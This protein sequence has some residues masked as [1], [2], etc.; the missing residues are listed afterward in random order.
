MPGLRLL[1]VIPS[2]DPRDGGPVQWV[3]A[4]NRELARRGHTSAVASFDAPGA[5][6]LAGLPF[7]T[8]PLGPG[9]G[10]YGFARGA[11]AQ[12]RALSAQYDALIVDGLWQY[13][14]AA[15]SAALRGRPTPY[16]VFPHGMLD[17]WFKNAYPLKHLKKLPYWAAFERRVLRHAA[18][19]IFTNAVEAGLATTSFPSSVWTAE[20]VRFGIE[21]VP[22]NGDALRRRFL[23]THPEL[24]G[25]R[26]LTFLGRLHEKKGYDLL[27]QAFARIADTD[28]AL[29]LLFVGPSD[30]ATSAHMSQLVEQSG[31]GSRITRIDFLSGDD[32]W[33]ALYASEAFCL[34]SHQEN[35]GIAI[36]EALACGVPVLISDKINIHQ[37]IAARHAGFVG[38]DTVDGTVQTLRAWLDTSADDR[39]R[40]KTSAR[41]CFESCFEIGNAAH[42]LLA[43]IGKSLPSKATAHEGRP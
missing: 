29:H 15:T 7:A 22:R 23:D 17:P 19:V 16:F 43:I 4:L 8:H 28:P 40:M 42:D 33:G 20:T 2:L 27:V 18:A 34:P 10:R 13:P 3:K 9:A 32:K 1:H 25:R 37:D 41:R 14:G 5:P 21:D 24:A 26:L 31:L 12:L 30:A 39:E 36:V 11:V 38:T 6:H 35:F